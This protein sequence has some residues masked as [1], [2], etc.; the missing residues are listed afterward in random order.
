MVYALSE[1]NIFTRIGDEDVGH[2]SYLATELLIK[3]QLNHVLDLL[4][5]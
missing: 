1:L 3:N 4:R 5:T 2:I